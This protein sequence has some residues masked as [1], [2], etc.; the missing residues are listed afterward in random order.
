[1]PAEVDFKIRQSSL[2]VHVAQ[3]ADAVH[4]EAVVLDG[5]LESLHAVP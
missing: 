2:G 1:M 4:D 3:R 5:S